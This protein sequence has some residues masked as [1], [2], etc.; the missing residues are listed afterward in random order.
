MPGSAGRVEV[1]ADPR[2]GMGIVSWNIDPFAILRLWSRQLDGTLSVLTASMDAWHRAVDSDLRALTAPVVHIEPHD[3]GIEVVAEL[4]AGRSR[5]ARAED[6]QERAHHRRRA[7]RRGGETRVES[8]AGP[9]AA[10][11]LRA[12]RRPAGRDR[13]NAIGGRHE[14]RRAARIPAA[15]AAERAHRGACRVGVGTCAG[16]SPRWREPPDVVIG[17]KG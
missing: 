17:A 10:R 16:R 12:H 14:A 4:P 9:E 6:R 5:P 11:T 13:C 3:E 1:R 7:P 2:H 15:P 8:D